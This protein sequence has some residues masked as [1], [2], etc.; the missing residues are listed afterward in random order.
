[1]SLE[2]SRSSALAHDDSSRTAARRID[3]LISSPNATRTVQRLGIREVHSLIQRA[4]ADQAVELVELLSARQV[5]GLVDLDCWAR[6]RI[7][8]DRFAEW[9]DRMLT[10]PDESVER[11]FRGLDLEPL[12]V[13]FREHAQVF[14]WEDDQD[15]LDTIDAPVLTSPDGT[16]A[17]VV[18]SDDEQAVRIRLLLDRAYAYDPEFG[19]RVLE[20][21]RWE[22]TSDMEERAYRF[23]TARLEDLGFVGLDTAWEVFAPID[24]VAWRRAL[25]T[26]MPDSPIR[27]SASPEYGDL[28]LRWFDLGPS[29]GRWSLTAAALER[30]RTRD[31]GTLHRSLVAQYS[32]LIQRVAVADGAPPGAIEPLQGAAEAADARVELALDFGSGGAVELAER[33]LV[34]T[35]LRDLHRVGWGLVERVAAQARTLARRE[36]LTLTGDPASLVPEPQADRLLGLLERR[37]VVSA[38]S[39]GWYTSMRELEATSRLLAD[40]AFLELWLFGWQRWTRGDLVEVVFDPARNQTPVEWITFR[41]LVLSSAALMHAGEAALRPLSVTE[42]SAWLNSVAAPGGDAASFV[43]E[44][45]ASVLRRD[46]PAG[47][48]IEAVTERLAS[49]YAGWLVENLLSP[50]NHYPTEI[51]LTGFMLAPR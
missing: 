32:A 35:P 6:D 28:E 49:E 42:A 2:R 36:N 17:I 9:L 18:P 4:G 37:P 43:A 30:I 46:R 26:T 20:A 29:P 25:E 39:G 40:I 16:Y 14:L 33:I 3:T 10:A 45:L 51:L 8:Q 7:D 15:L 48:S 24:P 50:S 44:A 1:M 34:G 38:S 11:W 31:D 41:H 22:L 23:R 5:Q 13:W 12:V 21:A 19:R 47:A 27:L